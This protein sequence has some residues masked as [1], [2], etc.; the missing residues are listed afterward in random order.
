MKIEFRSHYW[1]NTP[2]L[3]EIKVFIDDK[4]VVSYFMHQDEIWRLSKSL[5][6]AH[7]ELLDVAKNMED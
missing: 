5:R 4:E 7:D 3:R 1:P 2:N 6:L